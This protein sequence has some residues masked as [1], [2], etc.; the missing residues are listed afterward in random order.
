[1][2]KSEADA[3]LV[4]VRAIRWKCFFSTWIS[5][6]FPMIC[7]CLNL[8]KPLG[9]RPKIL[10]NDQQGFGFLPSEGIWK[11]RMEE[12]LSASGTRKDWAPLSR[13]AVVKTGDQ[14]HSRHE[15]VRHAHQSEKGLWR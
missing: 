13:Y 5:W 1:M 8:S 12:N 3:F 14:I 9:M 7:A 2:P 15:L 11:G 10:E 4:S 6:R